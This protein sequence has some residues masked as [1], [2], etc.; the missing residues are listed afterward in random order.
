M[1][2]RSTTISQLEQSALQEIFLDPKY[3]LMF[4][5]CLEQEQLLLQKY[6]SKEK[7]DLKTPEILSSQNDPIPN[8]DSTIIITQQYPK[9]QP[10][11]AKGSTG[12]KLFMDDI[13]FQ[14]LQKYNILLLQR[15]HILMTN[16]L[17]IR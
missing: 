7:R 12:N 1:T 10:N 2:N 8:Q 5:F 16:I 15:I 6:G 9:L 13:H 3:K 11:L 14:I 17:M 4:I